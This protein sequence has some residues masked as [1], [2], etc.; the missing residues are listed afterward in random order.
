MAKKRIFHYLCSVIKL[1]HHIE[2]LLLSNDC[3]IVPGW[4]ALI[5]HYVSARFTDGDSQMA[6]PSRN[7]TFN[8]MLTHN[9]GLLAGSLMRR[10]GMT[11]DSACRAI[12]L[13][14]DTMRHQLACDGEVALEGVGLFRKNEEGTPVFEPAETTLSTAR[15]LAL[16]TLNIKPVKEIARE[17]ASDID[18]TDVSTEHTTPRFSK[19]KTS[20][21]R[22]AASVAVFACVVSALTLPIGPNH[23][24]IVS[25][26][27]IGLN[28]DNPTTQNDTPTP[29]D[30]AAD[31][32]HVNG[33]LSISMPGDDSHAKIDTTRRA[34]YR[35]VVEYRARQA[36]RKAKSNTRAVSSAETTSK[37]PIAENQSLNI[38]E[39]KPL[40]LNDSDPYCLIV[41]SHASRTAAEKYISKHTSTPM[42][43]LEQD[44]KYR[45]Y[46]A[47]GKSSS[48][49][50]SA[51]STP[52]IRSQF[53][54]A[55]VCTR[56]E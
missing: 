30:V 40:T 54:G 45:V 29:I 49:A 43:V 20:L 37:S 18:D 5:G 47:T 33:T 7:I 17:N 8:P 56:A 10:H 42:K 51:L 24:S 34:M 53:P 2:Y 13:E 14:V 31:V 4:G 38:K 25:M 21:L 27:S 19:F 3:V 15:Y 41:S 48:Q 1:C 35:A 28:F 39:H 26:A 16:P 32:T 9:D 44:G 46:I 22:V 23:A 36:E 11:F 50:R 12:D 55:W 52:G 6:P